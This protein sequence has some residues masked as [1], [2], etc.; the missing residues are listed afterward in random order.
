MAAEAGC[1]GIP[2]QAGSWSCP[3]T[4][5]RQV[6]GVRALVEARGQLCQG[7]DGGG[8]HSN[9]AGEQQQL[10][11]QQDLRAGAAEEGPGDVAAGATTALRH[12]GLQA[13]SGMQP[14][15]VQQQHMLA[16]CPSR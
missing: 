6:D 9:L 16:G 8:M 12:Q 10:A 2:W 1:P 11:L 7:D 14:A 13:G 4:A 3:G 5:H 15:G